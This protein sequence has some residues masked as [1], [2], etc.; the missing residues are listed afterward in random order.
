[1]NRFRKGNVCKGLE[2][3]LKLKTEIT[4]GRID[5]ALNNPWIVNFIVLNV[6]YVEYWKICHKFVLSSVKEF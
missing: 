1:M 3:I 2:L 6:T 4:I 5:Q